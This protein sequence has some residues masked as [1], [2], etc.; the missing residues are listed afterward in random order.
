MHGCPVHVLAV[1]IVWLVVS[2]VFGLFL[3]RVITSSRI[4]D[5]ERHG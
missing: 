5:D 2:V 3:G 4:G 1:L